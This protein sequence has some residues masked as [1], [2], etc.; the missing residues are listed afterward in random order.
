ME[1][2]SPRRLVDTKTAAKYLGFT[3]HY[4]DQLRSQGKGPPYHRIGRSIRYDLNL[5]DKWLEDRT[6]YPSAT[7]PEPKEPSVLPAWLQPATKL[8]NGAHHV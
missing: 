5:L 8:S 3:P 6:V 7:T 2:A 1:T 4:L